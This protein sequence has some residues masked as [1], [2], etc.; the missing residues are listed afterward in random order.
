MRGWMIGLL[1]FFGIVAFLFYKFATVSL[2]FHI[3]PSPEE[4]QAIL[5]KWRVYHAPNGEFS[6]KFPIMPQQVS[7]SIVDPKTRTTRTYEMHISTKPDGSIF[8]VIE[9]TYSG[10]FSAPEAILKK[11][12]EE[13]FQDSVYKYVTSMKMVSYKG[14][15]ALQFNIGNDQIVIDGRAF[16]HNKSIYV[17][18][19]IQRVENFVPQESEFFFDSFTF[20]GPSETPLKP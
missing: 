12:V 8:S 14:L 17:I 3:P 6:A 2:H 11:T 10:D 4:V 1:I 13:L 7:H 20:N 18:A 5:E 15:E 9:A 19:V 16:I